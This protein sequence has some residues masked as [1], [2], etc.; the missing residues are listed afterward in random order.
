MIKYIFSVVIAFHFIGSIE[1]QNKRP[2]II[3]FSMD[4]LK[5]ELGIYGQ[6]N[7][8]S[9]HID[10]LSE[11]GVVFENAYCQQAVCA[12]SRIS[13]FG[14]LRP[15]RTKVWDLQTNMRDVNPDVITLPQFF[16]N[17]GYETVGLGKLMHGAKNNDPVSW[18]IPYIDKDDMVYADGYS[19]PAAYGK[20]QNPATFK[21]MEIAKAKKMKR[22]EVNKFLKKQGLNPATENLDVPDNAYVDGAT[23]EGGIKLLEKLS[24][25][26]KPFFLAL[27]YSKPHLPFVAPKKYWD[28]YK[29][30]D[31]DVASFQKHSEN[32]PGYAY[33]SWGELRAY[34]GIP[35]KGPLDME[36]QK[37][38]I[39]GY[40]ASVSYVDAQVGKVLDKVKELGL[41]KNTIIILWGDHGWHLGDHGLWAKHSNFEQATKVPLIIVAPGY[42]KGKRANTMAELVDMYPTILDYAGFEIPKVLEGKSLM[43][44]IKNSEIEIKDFALSQY[45]RGKNIMGYSMRT[46][47][48]RYTLWMKGDFHKTPSYQKPEIVGVEL[49]DYK[50]DPLERTSLQDDPAYA[51]TA[52]KLKAKLINL[53]KEQEKTFG[54]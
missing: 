30:E 9:P 48:Y 20:Y 54:Y 26:D 51:D 18:T 21:A 49:Y 45:P 23:S 8:K 12:A 44:A 7:I 40:K 24:K 5:P 42:A 22:K 53:L 14:G 4:D 11:Q 17:N 41:D 43:P 29:R 3:F 13:I 19:Y 36:T 28:L 32:S 35:D 25:S 31:M 52:K 50:K 38:L 34:A 16:K 15:D 46:K 2:N 47:R 37:K 27:G 10:R 33:H 1:A 6:T 39:H